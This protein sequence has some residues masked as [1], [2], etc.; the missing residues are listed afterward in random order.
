MSATIG[1][2]GYSHIHLSSM[3]WIA[4]PPSTSIDV[5]DGSAMQLTVLMLRSSISTTSATHIHE[6]LS[7]AST[8]RTCSRCTA[9][10]WYDTNTRTRVSVSTIQ[11][12]YTRVRV[13][14]ADAP[15][16]TCKQVHAECSYSRCHAVYHLRCTLHSICLVHVAT[17]PRC[18]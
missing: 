17:S 12:Y 9:T 10:G 16:C 4:L 6:L 13:S 15:A 3:T 5:L 7:S 1:V 14:T 2:C 8:A 11:Q 18:R